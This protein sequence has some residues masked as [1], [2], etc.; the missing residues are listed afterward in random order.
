MSR[1]QR[2]IKYQGDNRRERSGGFTVVELI[3]VVVV[4]SIL[5]AVT[6]V[7][8]GAWRESVAKTEVTSDLNNAYAGMEDA[9]N[10]LN[11][12]PTYSAG[13]LFDGVNSTRSVFTPSKYV[14]VTYSSGS[15]TT[16]CITAQSKEKPS[17]VRRINIATSSEPQ[18]GAC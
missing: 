17:I 10:R 5:A 4:I 3:L 8:Y 13:T 1:I 7:G 6:I 2:T 12:Y 16:Y 9:R 14:T 11:V 15:T 18:D